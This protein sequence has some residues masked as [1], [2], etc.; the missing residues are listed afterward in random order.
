M[1]PLR[2][3]PLRMVPHRFSGGGHHERQRTHHHLVR[4]ALKPERLGLSKGARSG[5]DKPL[6]RGAQP[7]FLLPR[8]SEQFAPDLPASLHTAARCH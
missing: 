5:M 3:V 1:V 4:S 6:V 7:T 2:M 8:A